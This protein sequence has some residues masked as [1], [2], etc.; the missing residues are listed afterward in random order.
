MTHI[1]RKCGQFRYFDTQLRHPE[2]RDKYV[3]DFGG[4]IGNILRA[5]ESAIDE[6]RY[7]CVDVSRDAIAAGRRER[8]RAHWIFYNRYNE[9]FNPD[10]RRG[11]PLPD[12]GRGFDYILAYSVFTHILPGEMRS[13]LADL[14]GLLND[15]GVLAFSFIDPFFHS[16]PGEYP[17]DN[18]RWR[19]DRINKEGL[20]V[21][22]ARA[23]HIVRGAPW[24]VLADDVSVWVAT[25]RL[26]ALSWNPGRSFH[27]YHAR[28]YIEGLYPHA[29]VLP[30]AHREMQH[31]C[32]IRKNGLR[33][34]RS[35]IA[36]A[37]CA[38]S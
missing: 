32:L 10:G 5:R 33:R 17:G 4:N 25:E 18:F 22:V 2:W 19:L 9:C 11:L 26:P 3:L 1:S 7:W 12:M 15:D 8:P 24:F 36:A 34:E 38:G 14:V 30:P 6:D 27:V 23:A 28:A 21:D 20:K 31:C 16:W 37:G 13:L 29:H 35:R